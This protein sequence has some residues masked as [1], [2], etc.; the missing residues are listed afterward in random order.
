MPNK[1][2]ISH[3]LAIEY[4]NKYPTAANLTLA[5]K[6]CKDHPL[7]FNTLETARSSIRYVR[8]K[9]IAEGVSPVVDATKIDPNRIPISHSEKK[10][11]YVIPS[12]YNRVLIISDL[13]IPYHDTTA[14]TTALQ[15]GKDHGAN[16]IL[17]NG[18]L[19]DFHHLSKFEK[20]IRKRRTKDEFDAALQFLQ[21]LRE[22]FPGAHIVWAEGNHDARYP[23]FLAAKALELFDDEYYTLQARL[24]LKSLRIH[25]V[26]DNQYVM[27]GKLSVSHG[28][29]IIR[30][31]FAPVNAARGVF[32]RTKES[33]LVGHT[34][35]VSEH[36]EKRLHG[37]L[38]TTWSTGCLCE[39]NPDYDPFVSKAAHGFAF[40]D[41]QRNG[42]YRVTNKRIINGELM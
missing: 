2:G 41:I 26:H 29:K 20:D 5:R 28:H 34:H 22:S 11:P 42:H 23:K 4:V 15:Y 24:Q 13:H 17:I 21:Y 39:L 33:H 32:L 16:C 10:A 8:K 35:S 30:G 18:D 36:S 1:L 9:L 31:I 12:K 7:L 25:F 6:L 38:V 40:V 19:L 3:E 14:V 37:E 27:A